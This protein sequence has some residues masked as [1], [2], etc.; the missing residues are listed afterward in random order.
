MFLPDKNVVSSPL[1]S[2]NPKIKMK[3]TK[4]LPVLYVRETTFLV[5]RVKHTQTTFDK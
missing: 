2:K 1:Q 3:T 5:L 4:I